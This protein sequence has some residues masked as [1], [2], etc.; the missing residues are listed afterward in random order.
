MAKTAT[1]S[2]SPRFIHQ[3]DEEYHAVKKARRSGRPPSTKEDMLKLKMKALETEYEK[4]FGRH[5]F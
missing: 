4:G 1:D 5:T 3:H 2:G